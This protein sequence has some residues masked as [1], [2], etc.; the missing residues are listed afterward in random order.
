MPRQRRSSWG[1]NEDAGRGRRRIR[2]WAEGSA[3]DLTLID[4]KKSVEITPEY[5]KSRSKNSAWLGQTLTGVATDVWAGGRRVLTD[6]VVTP[7][8]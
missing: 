8:H 7:Q 5:L 2:Y 4:P 6:G 1:S 3:A